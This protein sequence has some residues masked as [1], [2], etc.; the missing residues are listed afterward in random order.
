MAETLVKWVAGNGCLILVLLWLLVALHGVA[1]G[2]GV[3]RVGWCGWW[4]RS[5]ILLGPEGTSAGFPGF[6]VVGGL[7]FLVSKPIW[8]TNCVSEFRGCGCWWWGWGWP[9]F[10]N[11][12]VDASIFVVKL[13][14]ADGECLGTRSR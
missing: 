5:D 1:G 10:E 2:W 7:F 9:L 3:D 12:T 13:P 11:C 14:R 6:G 4:S 8:L